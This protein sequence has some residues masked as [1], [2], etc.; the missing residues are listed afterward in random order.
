MHC[1][2][3]GEL[4]SMRLDGRLDET[5]T[6]LLEDHL[7][8][9]SACQAEWHNLQALDGLLA[10]ASMVRAPVSLRVNVMA[11]L[12]RREQARRAITGATTLA[13]GTVALVL[14]ALAPILPGLLGTT[15]ILPALVSGGP[16]TFAQLFVLLGA[17]GRAALVLADKFAVPLTC[18]VLFSLTTALALNGLLIGAVR[19]VRAV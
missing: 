13:L 8:I 12:S 3:A 2:Q 14:L 4:M 19:R 1:K 15:D 9:C 7:A 11:R 17:L 18:L 10:S 16:E 6:A 5:A